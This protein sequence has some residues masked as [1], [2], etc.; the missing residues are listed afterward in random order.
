MIK[1]KNKIFNTLSLFLFLLL[2][3]CAG[4][5][6]IPKG[7]TVEKT[8]E[9]PC[10]NPFGMMNPSQKKIKLMPPKLV[11]KK[12]TEGTILD[13]ELGHAWGIE[14]CKHMYCIMYEPSAMGHTEDNMFYEVLA[15]PL[16]FIN[17]FRF[18]KECRKYLEEKGAFK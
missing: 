15:K 12:I 13:H 4:Q 3:G 5:L 18:C 14:E 9:R 11:P 8:N 16:Q 2:F 6:K 10:C 1:N 17:R 7:W